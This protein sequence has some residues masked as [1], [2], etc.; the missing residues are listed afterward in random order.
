MYCQSATHTLQT[1]VVPRHLS[2][3]D[4]LHLRLMW[5][6]LEVG[7][8][9]TLLLPA[10]LVVPMTI[11]DRFWVEVVRQ[12]ELLLRRELCVLEQQDRV[13][14]VSAVIW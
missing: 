3:P 14:L 4:K 1:L 13:L 5:D 2:V 7:M 10:R 11:V 8:Q 12:F 9:D 6:R